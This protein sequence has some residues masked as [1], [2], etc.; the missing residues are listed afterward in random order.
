MKVRPALSISPE[1][2]CFIVVK[3]REFD[4]KDAVTDP[5]SGS[6]ATDDAMIAVL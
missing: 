2:I 5:D 6:N 3:G 1:K 4:V